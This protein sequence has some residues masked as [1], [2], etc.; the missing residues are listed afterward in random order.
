MLP[1]G[2]LAE[3]VV[4]RSRL[5]VVRPP[6]VDSR[7]TGFRGILGALAD[8]E[9]HPGCG[10]WLLILLDGR[11]VRLAVRV[12]VFCVL[13]SMPSPDIMTEEGGEL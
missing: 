6:K 4:E 8:V 10:R 5:G 12:F 2:R 1:A 3:G 9:R 13:V 7:E 11:R